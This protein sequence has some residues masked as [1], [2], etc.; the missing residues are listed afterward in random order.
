MIYSVY[1]YDDRLW[2][3]Y[4]GTGSFPA[5]GFFRK[6]AQNDA[7]EHLLVPLPANASPVGSGPRPKGVIAHASGEHGVALS[8]LGS[9]DDGQ[10]SSKQAWLGLAVLVAGA[11]WLGRQSVPAEQKA[12]KAAADLG[13]RLSS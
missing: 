7:P 6:P 1:N 8:G 3:Y 11:F 2:D 10:P 5:T 4:E 13:R 12:R 9:T